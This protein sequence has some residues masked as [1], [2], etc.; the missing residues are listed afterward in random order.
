MVELRATSSGS[1][2]I[3]GFEYNYAP[4]TQPRTIDVN[5]STYPYRSKDGGSSG[6]WANFN[7]ATQ[8][9]AYF[10]ANGGWWSDNWGWMYNHSQSGNDGQ[11][12]KFDFKGTAVSVFMRT[13]DEGGL[14]DAY[15]DGEFLQTIDSKSAVN[16]SNAKVL[17]RTACT[18]AI[19]CWSSRSKETTAAGTSSSPG[20]ATSMIR[21]RS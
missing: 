3:E 17:E 9:K 4:S 12:V 1:I 7:P 21:P 5:S 15:L 2:A 10:T 6:S 8:N 18:A 19:M 11:S 20:S 13:Y 16:D 14:L